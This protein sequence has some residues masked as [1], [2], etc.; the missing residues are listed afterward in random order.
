VVI[1]SD[2]A[3]PGALRITVDRALAGD[4]LMCTL[5]TC[6]PDMRMFHDMRNVASSE[7]EI[8]ADV[9]AV[10][11]A[12][13]PGTWQIAGRRQA[14]S[15]ARRRDAELLIAVPPDMTARLK[16]EVK[17]APTPRSIDQVVAQIRSMGPAD[18]YLLVA[19]YL[20]RRTREL[21]RANAIAYADA[22]G[23]VRIA[24]E[25]PPMF[26]E[27][28]GADKNPWYQDRRIRSL[29][30]PAAASVIRA[31]CDFRPPYG[32]RELA[33]RAGL[34]AASVSRTVSFLD[35]E[36]LLTRTPKGSVQDVDW[37]GLV[38]RWA[39]DYS[40]SASSQARLALSPRG[41]SALLRNVQALDT[42]AV[43]GSLAA[44]RVAPVAAPALGAVYVDDLRAAMEVLDL[45]DVPTGANV[46][47]VRPKSPVA[48]ER[49]WERDGIRYAAMS[50]VAVDLLTSPGRG[51]AEGEALIEWMAA[52]EDAW[53]T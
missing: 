11:R 53:R 2:H 3:T 5:L 16:V 48:F 4:A 6:V 35:G 32:V 17:I 43:T 10:L 7:T 38:R 21:L 49:T 23:N 25:G 51:P 42:Y 45:R 1:V 27:L 40:F 13:L 18:G 41:L 50:Q 15:P 30:G 44:T 20:S 46:M 39:L 28:E 22:T 37:A 33:Q 12:R 47:L 8:L 26:I 36:A 29:R 19:D 9:V 52:N 24:L 14:S 31:L 34:S